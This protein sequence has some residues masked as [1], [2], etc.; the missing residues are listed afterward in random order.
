MSQHRIVGELKRSEFSQEK[1][2][3]YAY[4]AER[5]RAVN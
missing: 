5:K 4:E 2:L 3:T 1:I